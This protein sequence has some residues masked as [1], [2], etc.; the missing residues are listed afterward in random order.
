VATPTDPRLPLSGQPIPFYTLNP[1]KVGTPID[2]LYTYSTQN[3]STYN[4]FEVTA[5]LRRDKFLVFG[6]VTTDRLVTSSCDGSTATQDLSAR[7]AS[8]RDNPNALRFCDVNLAGSGQPAGVFK[9]TVKA[10]AAYSFPYDVQLSASF[11][12]IPGPGVRA[13]YT[14][15]SAIAGRPIIESTTGVATTIVNL[16]E[17]NSLFLPYQNRLDMRI[18]KTFKLDR[19]KIQGF[20]D[21]F[22]VFNA[23]TAM[24][25]NQTYGAVAA[26]NA[27]M[28]PTS[29][30]QGRFVRFGMQMNF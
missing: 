28:T 15:T 19:A 18:G 8:A 12:S 30:M 3:K 5:N 10:S 27:W 11:S 1:A 2:N 25:V 24:S 22:N 13:D 29:I 21:V 26:T 17:P 7:G 16:V 20:A 4:G 9:T 6:G 23:G 14:V